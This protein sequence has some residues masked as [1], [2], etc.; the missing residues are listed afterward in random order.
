MKAIHLLDYLRV[1]ALVGSIISANSLYAAVSGNTVKTINFDLPGQPLQSSLIEFALQANVTIIA[2]NDLIQDYRSNPVAGPRATDAALSDLLASAPLAFQ[3]QANTGSYI[4]YKK[5]ADVKI[6]PNATEDSSQAIEEIVVTGLSYPFRYHTL[7]NTQS[8]GGLNYFDSSRFINAIPQTLIKDQQPADL[9]DLLKYA[10]GITPGDGI[11]D[12]NDDVYIRGFERH[13]MYLDGFRLSESTGIKIL[14]VN[15]ERIEILK[16]PSTL[17]YGQGEPGGIVNVVRKKPQDTSFVRGELGAGSFGR[18][19]INVDINGQLPT[20]ADV[21]FRLIMAGDEKDTAGEINNIHKELIAP[22]LTWKLGSDTTL[23]VGYE[24]QFDKQIF[25]RN[26]VVLRPFGENF[27][28]AT[29]A[30]VAQQARPEFSSEFNLYNIELNHYFT[31]DWRIRG[32]Y[33]WQKEDRIGIRT[34]R[35]SLL[36]TDILLNHSELG[37]DFYA[38]SMAGQVM[39]PAII[40]PQYPESLYSLGKIRSLYD[41]EGEETANNASLDVAGSFTTGNVTH[42]LTLGSDWHRQDVYKKYNVEARDLFPSRVWQES[43]FVEDFE[44]ILTTIVN[45][46][47]TLGKLEQKE[48]RLVYD[49]YGFY[50]QD[51]IELNEQWIA[52]AGT[53]YTI[54]TGEHSNI[55]DWVFTELPR[56]KNF[57]AQLGL[58]FKPSD[59]HSLFANYSEGMRANYH[60]DDLGSK[61]ANPELS[62]QIEVGVKSQLFEGRFISSLAFFNI[63]KQNIVDL[64]IVEGYQTLVAAHAENIR[65]M[66]FDFTW[67]ASPTLNIVGALALLDPQIT[68]GENKGEKPA[69]VANETASIFAH[70]MVTKNFEVNAGAK[71]VSERVGQSTNLPLVIPNL[72]S[73]TGSAFLLDSYATIDLGFAYAFTFFS[74]EAKFQLAIKNVFNEKYYTARVISVRENES[75]NRSIV[76]ALGVEF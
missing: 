40:K 66:D 21:S 39:I 73:D 52:S 15:I 6:K 30:Q 70:Y 22:S 44:N 67:Q 62:D 19:Y 9:G 63:D 35:E 46:S 60:I 61:I 71:Y 14:P 2:D 41:E 48:L 69:L 74:T 12:T 43:E 20:T 16:G 1:G 28:G 26:I 45:S 54:T 27:N 33:F 55:T 3:Y 76:A 17:L 47:K 37:N 53:R 56:H 23:D 72:V 8:Q 58:V 57:S 34:T 31:P 7:T 50:I 36:Q 4:I 29:L 59:S 75:E 42:R 25:N 64:T 18:Q 5:V 24:F 65:G 32:K 11:S 49:D 68:S 13:A 10:S 51:S 38:L